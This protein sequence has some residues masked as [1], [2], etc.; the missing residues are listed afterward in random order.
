VKGHR[1]AVDVK[2][3]FLARGQKEFALLKPFLFEKQKKLFPKIHD[4]SL[5]NRYKVQGPGSEAKD[6]Y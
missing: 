3:A 6:P 5:K 2:I 4:P 1:T